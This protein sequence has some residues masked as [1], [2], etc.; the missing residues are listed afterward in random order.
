MRSRSVPRGFALI[1][2]RE[3]A[4]PPWNAA[5]PNLTL[6]FSWNLPAVRI[7]QP[8]ERFEYHVGFMTDAQAFQFPD[9]TASTN[10]SG[11]SVPC[12]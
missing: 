12:P 4:R 9:G 8:G 6:D 10:F 11:F 2:A 7:I 5:P 1:T 3:T